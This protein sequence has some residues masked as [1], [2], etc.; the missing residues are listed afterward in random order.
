MEV[1][2]SVNRSFLRDDFIENIEIFT[3]KEEAISFNNKV[4][5]GLIEDWENIGSIHD[6]REERIKVGEVVSDIDRDGGY[7]CFYKQG[8]YYEDCDEVFVQKKIVNG[9]SGENK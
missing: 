4:I 8:Y 9:N 5:D 6:V 1:W 2:I 3:T 7:A